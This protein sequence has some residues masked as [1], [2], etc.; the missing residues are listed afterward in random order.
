MN[1]KVFVQGREIQPLWLEQEYV[2]S[3]DKR[4]SFSEINFSQIGLSQTDT[5]KGV[6][7][8]GFH[9]TRIGEHN[10]FSCGDTWK[11]RSI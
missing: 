6:R 1:Q 3:K 10:P 8:K 2:K 11:K 7:P 4:N 5:N 9:V